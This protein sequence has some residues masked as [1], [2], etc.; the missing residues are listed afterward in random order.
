VD[1]S[2][3]SIEAREDCMLMHPPLMML[4]FELAGIE[5]RHGLLFH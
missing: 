3:A 2:Q 1:V 5:V 4:V